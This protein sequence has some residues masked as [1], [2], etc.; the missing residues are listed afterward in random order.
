LIDIVT[1]NA[2]E[3]A[4]LMGLEPQAAVSEADLV[5]SLAQRTG[6]TVLM[7]LGARGALLNE[8][9]QLTVIPAQL[10]ERPVDTTGAGDAFTGA[11]AVAIAEGRPL[12]EAAAFAALAGAHAVTIDEVIPAL[13]RRADLEEAD[14]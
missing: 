13:P 2:T 9:G 6:G 8:E 14:S 7:T 5:A 11:L 12:A 10:V 4:I 1:P 3:A